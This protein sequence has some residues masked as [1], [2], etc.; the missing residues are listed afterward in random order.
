MR[1]KR[2]LYDFDWMISDFFPSEQALPDSFT[3]VA[4]KRLIQ[5][6]ITASRVASKAAG[7]ISLSLYLLHF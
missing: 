2:L 1:T 3:L 5:I 6:F 4:K 7:R